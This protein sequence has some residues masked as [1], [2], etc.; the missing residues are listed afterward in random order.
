MVEQCATI[1]PGSHYRLVLRCYIRPFGQQANC[2]RCDSVCR[3]H[4][5]SGTPCSVRNINVFVDPDAILTDLAQLFTRKSHW[6]ASLWFIC[7]RS[8]KKRFGGC[9]ATVLLAL[10]QLWGVQDRR[11]E[12]LVPKKNVN[13]YYR[14]STGHV[15]VSHASCPSQSLRFV[16][17]TTTYQREKSIGDEKNDTCEEE[18]GGGRGVFKFRKL[19]SEECKTLYERIGF[20]YK[21]GSVSFQTWTRSVIR[22][23]NWGSCSVLSVWPDPH[24]ATA[25]T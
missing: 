15:T 22:P 7:R 13:F 9:Q 20:A 12:V 14:T 11:M 21:F 1:P 4:S 5:H 3:S 17:L 10:T 2:P 24:S 6:Y 18:E 16:H 25:L 19:A 23:S 8:S